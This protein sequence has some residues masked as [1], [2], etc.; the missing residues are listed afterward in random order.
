MKGMHAVRMS[1]ITSPN[2]STSDRVEANPE[3]ASRSSRSE[4]G[5]VQDV[6]ILP[7]LIGLAGKADAAAF[8]DI[9]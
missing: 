5:A 2:V 9:A 7:Q 3:G 1:L 8:H 6:G 4:I